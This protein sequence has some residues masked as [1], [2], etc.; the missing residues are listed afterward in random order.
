MPAKRLH[1]AKNHGLSADLAILLRPAGT[2]AKPASGCDEDGCSTLR[3]GH[4]DS[5]YERIGLRWG[6]GR[7]WRTALTM[8]NG[9]NRVIPI[10]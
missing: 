7:G 10:A 8:M 9:E 4:Q 5:K 6:V 2:G 3:S 1:G